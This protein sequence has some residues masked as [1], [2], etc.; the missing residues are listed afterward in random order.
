MA[1]VTE[2][3]LRLIPNPERIATLCVFLRDMKSLNDAITETIRKRVLPRCLEFVDNQ[4]LDM[5]R[6]HVGL[7]IPQNANAML[8]VEIDGDEMDIE[9]L[10]EECG[11][12]M[13]ESGALDILVAQNHHERQR[14]W[15]ARRNLSRTMREHAKRKLSEDIVVPRSRVTDLL[16][17]VRE[18]EELHE[19]RMPT[20]GHAGDG[21]L[22]VNFLWDTPDERPRIDAAIK[23]L[24]ESV[25]AMNGTLSGEHGIGI[26]KAPYLSIEQSPELI[27]LQERIKSTFDPRGILNPGKIFPA[28]VNRF[29]GSC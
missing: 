25:I 27:A 28:A 23:N 18:L 22:H 9:R 10:V 12:A 8:L 1:V 19:I 2:A 13:M 21:N 24:F 14:V 16:D 7:T 17:R 15:N 29:H 20:Y 11:N 5:L 26:L 3:T 4:A 6:P